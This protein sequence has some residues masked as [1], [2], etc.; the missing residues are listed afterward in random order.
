MKTSKR[1]DAEELKSQLFS[2]RRYHEIGNRPDET[3]EQWQRRERWQ[4]AITW[5]VAVVSTPIFIGLFWFMIRN[6]GPRE[7]LPFWFLLA[8]YPVF[9]TSLPSCMMILC[10]SVLRPKESSGRWIIFGQGIFYRYGKSSHTFIPFSEVYHIRVEKPRSGFSC[11]VLE[12]DSQTLRISE[13]S[14]NAR[15]GDTKDFLPFLNLLVER[16]RQFCPMDNE[17][18][19]PLELQTII[20]RRITERYCC[21]IADYLVMAAYALPLLLLFPLYPLIQKVE[22]PLIWGVM[23]GLCF[24]IVTLGWLL[25]GFVER[26]KNRRIDRIIKSLESSNAE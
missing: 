2:R 11:I 8:F 16:M 5:G 21:R 3:V 19:N 22:Y 20:R 25:N 15:P 26:W 4:W 14:S 9:L 12:T 10:F 1:Q 6:Y 23:F 17:T 24:P 7:Q 18:E 13:R